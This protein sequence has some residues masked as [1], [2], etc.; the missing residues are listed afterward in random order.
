[1]KNQFFIL[2]FFCLQY[3]YSPGQSRKGEPLAHTFSVVAR[4]SKTGEMGLAV[5]SH[6]FSVGTVVSWGEAGVGVIAT[7]SFVNKSFGI[8]GLA[9]LKE[10]LNPQEVMEKLLEQDEGKDFRQVA[11]LDTK[12]GVASHT[13]KKC[14]MEAGHRNG[15]DFSVQANMMLNENV[16]PAMEKAWKEN[17]NLPL[18]ER[19]VAVLKAGQQAGGDVR[20]KQSAALLVVKG[21][22]S[23][24]PWQDR[25]IDLRVDDHVDPILELERLLK[26]HRA[27]D[28]MNEGDLWVEKGN[29][30]KA[31]EA[32]QAAMNLFPKNLEMQ[33]WTAVTLANNG[34]FEKA[35]KI[36]K[37]VF[38][39]EPHW[40]ILTKRLPPVGLLT[41]S[42]EELKKLLD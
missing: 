15:Q 8:K 42:E 25:L 20:G 3:F 33:Y 29:M 26:V 28:F 1:M 35:K 19:L 41:L 22:A 6:W 5:Q 2:L 23:D 12:G 38:D 13:G 30:D 14:I 24:A 16:V 9:L 34:E 31:M 37:R 40:K 10:G 27:Y 4:D 21:K 18:G 7:Q 17:E 36:L 39:Q 11:I 32:Y